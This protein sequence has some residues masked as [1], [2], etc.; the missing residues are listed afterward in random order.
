M[1]RHPKK[2]LIVED[3]RESSMWISMV[4]RQAGFNTIEAAD[5]TM[6]IQIARKERP[7][8][9]LL[10]I[11]LPAGSGYFVLE[12]LR[13]FEETKSAPVIVMTGDV[14]LD[15]HEMRELGAAALFKKPMDVQEFL[16]T[17]RTVMAN[18]S[19]TQMALPS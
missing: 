15:H 11:H 5:G 13:K 17:I 18:Y 19:Q 12:S 14:E 2:I 9:V 10:D 1:N 3:H 8:M 7:D 16:N 4:L 6:G